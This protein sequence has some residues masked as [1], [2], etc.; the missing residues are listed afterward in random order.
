M[1]ASPRVNPLRNDLLSQDV[2]AQFRQPAK[3]RVTDCVVASHDPTAK[4]A[5]A[6]MMAA[7]MAEMESTRTAALATV[8]ASLQHGN[9]LQIP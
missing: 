2:H 1:R 3:Q 7:I 5:S 8:T 4:L 6:G 9:G